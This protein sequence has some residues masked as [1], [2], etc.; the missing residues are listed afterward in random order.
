MGCTNGLPL[1]KRPGR[2]IPMWVSRVI[3]DKIKRRVR[4]VDSL[5]QVKDDTIRFAQMEDAWD[6]HLR[7]VAELNPPMIYGQPEPTWY[8][9][10]WMFLHAIRNQHHIDERKTYKITQKFQEIIDEANLRRMD[11]KRE[12]MLRKRQRKMEEYEKAVK[13]KLRALRKEWKNIQP[14]SSVDT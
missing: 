12:R 13:R 9:G 5:N 6:E 14:V 1:L 11:I 7:K 4:Q 3:N 10:A 8:D 2:A